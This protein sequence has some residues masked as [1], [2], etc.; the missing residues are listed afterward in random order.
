ML[1]I[2]VSQMGCEIYPAIQLNLRVR[3]ELHKGLGTLPLRLASC[4]LLVPILDFVAHHFI[5]IRAFREWPF[6][7]LPTGVNFAS[8]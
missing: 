8:N 1:R 6:S 7:P 3:R 4:R 5:H 2:A